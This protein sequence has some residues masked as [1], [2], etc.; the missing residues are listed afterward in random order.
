MD[1]HK[2]FGQK[3]LTGIMLIALL[4]LIADIIVVLLMVFHVDLGK[5]VENVTDNTKFNNIEVTTDN[6]R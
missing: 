2:H 5:V 3:T 1:K 6:L 4:F